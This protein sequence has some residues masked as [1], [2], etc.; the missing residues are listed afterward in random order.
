[1][2]KLILPASIGSGIGVLVIS[3]VIL[4]VTIS[5]KSNSEYPSLKFTIVGTND[6]HGKYYPSLLSRSDTLEKYG[7]GGLEVMASI[8]EILKK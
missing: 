4:G 5:N 7:Y 6:L 1:M 2:K 8:I 3:L